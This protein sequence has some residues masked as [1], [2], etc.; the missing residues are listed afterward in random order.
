MK[1]DSDGNEIAGLRSVLQRMPLGTYTGWNPI[2][3]GI[4]KG[5]GAEPGQRLYL[6]FAKTKAERIAKGD[7]RPSIEERYPNIWGYY[8]GAVQVANELAQQRYLL[9]EDA[10]R[11]INQLLNDMLASNLLP[12]LGELVVDAEHGLVVEHSDEPEDARR[13]RTI[14]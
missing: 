1:V 4:F 9:P 10:N 13:S 11:L 7:P 2:A 6:P 8:F 3:T 12:K 14:N 5:P